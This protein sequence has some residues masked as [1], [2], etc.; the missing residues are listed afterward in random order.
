ALSFTSRT[1]KAFLNS[2]TD[3][4]SALP[5][6][7]L[8]LI[9]LSF[10]PSQITVL[11][12]LKACLGWGSLAQVIR[13][14]SDILI[15]GAMVQS[16][17]SQGITRFR[18]ALKYLIPHL[19]PLAMSFFPLLV[20]SSLLTIASLDYFGLAFPIPVPNL[21]EMFRQYQE[22]PEAWWLF[23]FPILILSGLLWG[24]QNIDRRPPNRYPFNHGTTDS[25]YPR[26][27]P[28]RAGQL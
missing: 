22:H 9:A 14:E 19:I 20:F 23:V 7:P 27:G 5:F 17:L 24:F 21:A 4:I 6:L 13:M 3:V 2:G 10:F 1:L 28:M 12:L 11:G 18:I 25:D 8:A 16:A 15:R 26:L